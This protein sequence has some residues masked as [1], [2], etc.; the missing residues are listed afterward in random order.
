[1]W[2]IQSSVLGLDLDSK[3]LNPKALQNLL[4]PG[5]LI[6]VVG[7]LKRRIASSE[8][9]FKPGEFGCKVRIHKTRGLIPHVATTP[10][11]EVKIRT[12]DSVLVLVDRG[13]AAAA[14]FALSIAGPSAAD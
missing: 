8:V 1:M 10:V 7:S 12:R 13:A 2:V 14:S 11:I 6:I 4:L 5:D 3:G 9:G